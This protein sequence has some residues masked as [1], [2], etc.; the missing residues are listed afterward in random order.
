MTNQ[1]DDADIVGELPSRAVN[2]E[3][4]TTAA[5]LNPEAGLLLSSVLAHSGDDLLAVYE[6]LFDRFRQAPDKRRRERVARR[7]VDDAKKAGR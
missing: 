3:E 7:L 6:D 1:I 4:V 5:P 2:P